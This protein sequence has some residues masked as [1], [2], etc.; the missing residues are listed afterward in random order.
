M[1]KLEPDDGSDHERGRQTA[2]VVVDVLQPGSGQALDRL[3]L[4]LILQAGVEENA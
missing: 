3:G 4:S 1:D 2:S